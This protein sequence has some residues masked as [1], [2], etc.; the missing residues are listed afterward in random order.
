MVYV[1]SSAEKFSDN[2]GMTGSFSPKLFGSTYS[3]ASSSTDVMIETET[4][5]KLI[6]A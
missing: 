4:V 3:G 5:K 1:T 2:G 6:T